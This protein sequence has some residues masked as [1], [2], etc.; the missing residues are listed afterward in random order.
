VRKESKWFLIKQSVCDHC[1]PETNYYMNK[2]RGFCVT[3]KAIFAIIF[4]LRAKKRLWDT[5][6]VANWNMGWPGGESPDYA[7]DWTELNIA[8][9]G[10]RYQVMSN[11]NY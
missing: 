6:S 2:W 5:I 4:G 3:L 11:G 8:V 1:K 10:F 9:H 7:L